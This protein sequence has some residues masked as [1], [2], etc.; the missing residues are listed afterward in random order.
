MSKQGDIRFENAEL[1]EKFMG[2][3]SQ[4]LGI[5]FIEWLDPGKGQSWVDI[6]CGHGAFT[7]QIIEKCSPIVCGIDPSSAHIE[8][9]KGRALSVPV[10]FQIGDAMSLPYE[11]DSFHLGEVLRQFLFE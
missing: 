8:I 9:A 3:W 6:G 7:S 10:N 11:S 2:V 4:I 1:Y 5:K